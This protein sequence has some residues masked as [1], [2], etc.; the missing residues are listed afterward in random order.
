MARPEPIIPSDLEFAQPTGREKFIPQKI[1]GGDKYYHSGPHQLSVEFFGQRYNSEQSDQ[2]TK[3]DQ[4][5]WCSRPAFDLPTLI[6]AICLAAALGGGLGG[7]LAAHRKSSRAKFVFLS[8]TL[9]IVL[10]D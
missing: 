5:S 7:G 2:S 1:S 9:C 4:R 3:A 10:T 6:V 8:F